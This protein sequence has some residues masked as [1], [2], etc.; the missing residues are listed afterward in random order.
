MSRKAFV[1]LLGAVAIALGGCSDPEKERLKATTQATYDPKTGKLTRLTADLNK[2]GKIDAWTYMDG[3]KVLRTEL[4]ADQDGKIEKWEYHGDD[5]KVAKVALS[6]EKNGKQD[7][8]F[9]PGPDGKI[10]RAEL[11]SEQD[12]KKIDRWEW[13]ENGEA[14]RVE[15]DASGDGKVDKWQTLKNGSIVA[16]LLDENY[17]GKPDRRLNYGPNGQ[18]LSIESEPDSSGGF[19]KKVVVGQSSF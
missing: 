8:W 18:L 2:D 19:R 15:E 10:A 16:V 14:V 1:F 6:R 11:S 13:H 9:Y 7:A 4:D 5:G 17:D 12:E 3:T